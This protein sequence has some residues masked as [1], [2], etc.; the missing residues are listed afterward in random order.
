MSADNYGIIA[1]H[2]NKWGV[3]MAFSSDELDDKV[4]ISGKDPMESYDTHKEALDY[5]GSEYWEYGFHTISDEISNIYDTYDALRGHMKLMNGSLK[6]ILFYVKQHPDLIGG[7]VSEDYSRV[8]AEAE[9][10]LAAMPDF[11][12]SNE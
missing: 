3:W 6:N 7:N 11:E 5:C 4:I 9:K 2:G 12:D 1:R 10:V 8:V